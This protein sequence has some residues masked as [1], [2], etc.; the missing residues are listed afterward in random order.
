ECIAEMREQPV[1][2]EAKIDIGKI[3][4]TSRPTLGN[5][6]NN[7]AQDFAALYPRRLFLLLFRFGMKRASRL[8]RIVF[9]CHRRERAMVRDRNPGTDR[10]RDARA[11]HTR[12]HI[13]C[14]LWSARTRPRFQSPD[15]SGSPH[16]K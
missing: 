15:A 12:F 7:G 5:S 14:W 9:C 8:G 1:I 10:N 2:L 6:W 16:S 13:Q 4:V 11:T 3:A